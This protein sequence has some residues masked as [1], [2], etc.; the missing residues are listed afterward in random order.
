[1]KKTTL[2]FAALF[3]AA[4][5]FS[6]TGVYAGTAVNDVV[7]M[8]NKAYPKHKKPIVMFTHKKHAEDYK[9]GCGECHHDDKGKPLSLKMGDD[10]QN[11]IECHKKVD[12][13]PKGKKL[14]DKEKRAYHYEAIHQNCKGCHKKFND[15]QKKAGT[16]K[17]APV[18]CKTCHK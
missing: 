11:C 1:M 7:K 3:V 13:K 18:G 14:S 8:E 6:A 12:K 4:V 10:V 17:K 2:L 15:E 5:V 16:Q 9:A